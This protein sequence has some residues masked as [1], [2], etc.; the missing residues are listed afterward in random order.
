MKFYL[1]FLILLFL[2]MM[3]YMIMVL[4]SLQ[5]SEDLHLVRQV[6]VH[7]LNQLLADFHLHG[8]YLSMLESSLL[9]HELINSQEHFIQLLSSQVH[10]GH[11]K[12]FLLIHLED[13]RDSFAY[14]NISIM[15]YY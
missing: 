2:R 6:L 12:Y 3:F 13:L 1:R 15:R 14:L 5:M 8:P 11:I 9:Q 10:L 7:H 4:W